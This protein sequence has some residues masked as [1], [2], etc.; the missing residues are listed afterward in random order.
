[1]HAAPHWAPPAAQHVLDRWHLVRHRRE[2][3]ER[4]LDLLH[5]RLAGLLTAS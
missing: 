1:M 5:H 2:A 4:L 3:L